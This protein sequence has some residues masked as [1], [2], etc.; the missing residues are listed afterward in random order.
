MLKTGRDNYFIYE[1]TLKNT[2]IYNEAG[3]K[4]NNTLNDVY[5]FLQYRFASCDYAGEYG[6]KFMPQAGTWG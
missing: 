5:L 4:H 3:D 1:Y 2:G 6:Y